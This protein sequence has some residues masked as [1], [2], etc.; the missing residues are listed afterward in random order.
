MLQTIGSER[1]EDSPGGAFEP[2]P[3]ITCIS[4][5]DTVVT[6]DQQVVFGPGGI[7]VADVMG[8]DG[9]AG[10]D[11]EAVT[12]RPAYSRVETG[13]DTRRADIDQLHRIS[14]LTDRGAGPA[15]D[16]EI[17]VHHILD[18]SHL[19]THLIYLENYF[20]LLH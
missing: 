10:T 15:T 6:A 13:P 9:H 3:G 17:P 19:F 12:A 11:I 16:T 14:F 7:I 18:R 4:F 2:H 20:L 8:V 1:R 5:E